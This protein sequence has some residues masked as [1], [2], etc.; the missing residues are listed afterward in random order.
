[1][2]GATLAPGTASLIMFGV[3]FALLVLRVP[4]AMALGLAC[5]P[6]FLI[7]ERLTP[8][9]LVQETFNAYNSFI[10]LAVPFFLLTANLMNV[11]GITTRLVR[12]SRDLV[13][14][15]P[16]GLA[17][18]NVVLSIFFAGISGS[19]TADAA[20]Q[21]KLFIEAQR[22]EGYDDSFSVAIT[23]VS[24]VLAV[25]IPPSILMVVWGGLLTV[26]IGGLFLAGIIPGLLIGLAQMATV[27]VYAKLRNYPTYPR[28][29]LVETLKA[30]LISIP[31]LMTPLIIIGGKIFG[32][33]TATESACIAVLYAAVLTM[34]VYREMD[35]KG[36][37]G[38][39]LET[40]RLTGVAL[41]CVGTASAFGWLLAYYQIPKALLA[42]VATWGM[43]PVTTGFFIAGVFLVV[44]CFLD[45]IPAIVIVGTVLEPLA[46]SV[47][48]DPIHFAIIG[49]VSLAF[50]LVT[51]P[52][53]LCLMI[54]CAVAKIRMLDAIKDVMIMLIPML[55][56]LALV[57]MFPQVSLFLPRLFPPGTL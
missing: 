41:F 16:G 38:A 42:G 29:T 21:S 44:G 39:L 24:A 10:L 22:K 31:A 54:S 7:E 9:N 34:L 8:Q 43:G 57:I 35:L 46:K 45:A 11:G 53:G 25:I 20:S 19:S 6:I 32:W 2:T 51:P 33:F 5:V 50:G 12:L 15:F 1:M 3:F 40:G 36:L 17:Q 23:A 56:V 14:H 26:S 47:G 52:Y 28:A 37:H 18:V 49:I 13:G 30:I 27:H 4:V 48:L 55:L